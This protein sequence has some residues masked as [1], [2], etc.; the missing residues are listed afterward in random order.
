MIILTES[1]IW[2]ESKEKKNYLNFLN[3]LKDTKFILKRICMVSL[4]GK[5]VQVLVLGV[6]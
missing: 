3:R 1:V 4:T 5:P 2:N 6:S